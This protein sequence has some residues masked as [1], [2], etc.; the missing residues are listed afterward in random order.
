MKNKLDDTEKLTVDEALSLL[1]ITDGKVHSLENAGV[2]MM[3]CNIARGRAV[4]H[5]R[6]AKDIRIAGPRARA[7]GHGL[8]I[9]AK[10]DSSLFLETNKN[11]L[12]EILLQRNIIY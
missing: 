10:D 9:I 3:G 11:N 12:A 8:L 7:L 5:I 4:I 6:E 1:L 2:A